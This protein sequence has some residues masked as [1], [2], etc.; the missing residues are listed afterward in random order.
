M[1]WLN[2]LFS[3]VKRGFALFFC[4]AVFSPVGPA[5]R[6]RAAAD[7]TCGWISAT[8]P[9]ARMR[10]TAKTPDSFRIVV[11]MIYSPVSVF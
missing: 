9:A 7:T 3:A 5:W 4:P 8:A 1:A 2:A 6:S 10:I 11:E